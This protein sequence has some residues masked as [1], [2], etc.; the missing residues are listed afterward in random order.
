[1]KISLNS[2][3]HVGLRSLGA[4][5]AIATV[6]LVDDVR[7]AVPFLVAYFAFWLLVYRLDLTNL[8]IACAL[9]WLVI[10]AYSALDISEYSRP[11]SRATVLAVA[12]VLGLGL[13]FLPRRG[14]ATRRW[15]PAPERVN[16]RVFVAILV[17]Y[18]S[19]CV[20]N[21]LLAGYVP[22]VRGVLT[23]DTGYMD[24]G[25]KGVYGLFN[26]FA[27]AFGVTA[28]YLWMVNPG[29]RLYAASFLLVLGMF[30]LFVTRQ[31][32][33]SLLVEAFIVYSCVVRRIST[34]L[35]LILAVLGLFGFG[36]IGD[37]RLGADQDIAVLAGI[38]EKYNWLPT[39]FIWL[40]AYCYFNILNLDNVA[41]LLQRPAYDGSSLATLLPSFIR[42]EG[43]GAEGVL[44]VSTF[45]VSSFIA[46][47]VY[48]VGLW[49]LAIVFSLLCISVWW[50]VRLLS[51]GRLFSGST[52]YA[53]MYFCFAF[54]FFVN[55]WFYL[56]VIFQLAFFPLLRKV[57][58]RRA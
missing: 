43:E 55:S 24:F 57:L 22:L 50:Y 4:A 44:E 33:V 12:L 58:F 5:I 13:I 2:L 37:A 48:D 28:F 45:T 49:G 56:P 7:S 38:R 29:R 25:V 3:L 10:L 15:V 35:I 8:W 18:L 39:P 36:L 14:I 6:F 26:A 42:P 1:L 27:N 34:P 41:T 16:D 17:V 51:K 31:N 11:V 40:F 32:M 54:S 21:V 20:L 23:G 52:G 53:V 19:F 9:P 30:F 46:P 47:L